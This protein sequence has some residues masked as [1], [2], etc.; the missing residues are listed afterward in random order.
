VLHVPLD[1]PATVRDVTVE[2]RW[3]WVATDAGLVR[4]DRD[5]VLR[6]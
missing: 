6:R 4:F 3:L 2:G 5:A 1:V